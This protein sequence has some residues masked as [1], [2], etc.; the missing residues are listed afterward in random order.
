MRQEMES[1]LRQVQGQSA[2]PAKPGADW[3]AENRN[4]VQELQTKLNFAYKD[5]QKLKDERD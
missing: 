4:R 1:V 2:Q 5:L 3:L